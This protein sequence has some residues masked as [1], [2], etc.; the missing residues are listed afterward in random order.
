MADC[1]QLE[2]VWEHEATKGHPR[3][4]DSLTKSGEKLLLEM[5]DVFE[6]MIKS[7]QT[8]SKKRVPDA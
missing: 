1:D 7:Y 2:T 4:F 5:N 6:G 8:I 3:K